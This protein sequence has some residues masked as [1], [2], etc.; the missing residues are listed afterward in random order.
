MGTFTV[1][2]SLKD[3]ETKNSFGRW[4]NGGNYSH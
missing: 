4:E 1:M 2:L 3:E